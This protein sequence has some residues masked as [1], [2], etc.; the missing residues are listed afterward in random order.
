[1]AGRLAG[2]DA[3]GFRWSGQS[4]TDVQL[5]IDDF[6]PTQGAG[7]VRTYFEQMFPVW[8]RPK[9]YTV[10][11]YPRIAA[12]MLMLGGDRDPFFRLPEVY[13]LF[14]RV[15]RGEFGVIP[16]KPHQLSPIGCQMVLDYL[17]RHSTSTE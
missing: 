8:T 9:Q 1:M 17:L 14:Q 2:C 5:R 13:A 10:A 6:E 7:Y 3:T 16:G 4:S 12:P 11:D 15:P